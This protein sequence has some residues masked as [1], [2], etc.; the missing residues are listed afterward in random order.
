[1]LGT[2]TAVK[3]KSYCNLARW[4]NCGIFALSAVAL[5]RQLLDLPADRWIARYEEN[6]M[7]RVA[8]APAANLL[9]ASSAGQNQ[10]QL[11]QLPFSRSGLADTGLAHSSVVAGAD[12]PLPSARPPVPDRAIGPTID[13]T[14]APALLI[15]LALIVVGSAVAVGLVRHSQR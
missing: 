2:A 6:V 4:L 13:E 3:V 12:I 7:A 15:Y 11:Q 14:P 9:L 10:A 1:S 5:A 8:L